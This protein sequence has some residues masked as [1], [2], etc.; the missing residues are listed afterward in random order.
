[1]RHGVHVVD[2]EVRPVGIRVVARAAAPAA[3]PVTYTRDVVAKP[4]PSSFL[5][6]AEVRVVAAEPVLAP[7]CK[8][9][10]HDGVLE[11]FDAM[12]HA[13]WDQHALT[14]PDLELLRADD[15]AQPPESTVAI[16]S[17]GCSWRGTAVPVASVI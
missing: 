6:I 14:R 16:C 2:P 8:R 15:E 1:M 5:G 13:A 12:R 10:E 17:F 7:R 9:V 3:R 11:S 4:R